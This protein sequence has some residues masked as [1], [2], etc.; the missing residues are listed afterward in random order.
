MFNLSFG[1]DFEKLYET[2]LKIKN[3]KDTSMF[4]FRDLIRDLGIYDDGRLVYFEENKYIN[5]R[6]EI[7]QEPSQFGSLLSFLSNQKINTYCE[8]GPFKYWSFVL[9]CA[10]LSRNTNNI[11]ALGV[12]YMHN[13]CLEITQ[14]LK[15]LNIDHTHYTRDSHYIKDR[16]FDL[17]FID[18]DHSYHGVKTDW[19]NVGQYANICLFHDINDINVKNCERDQ[20]GPRRVFEEL[21]GA[22]ITFTTNNPVMGIGV[23]FP[24]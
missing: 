18:A 3:T 21:E 13:P 15:K 19:I 10:A 6:S 2:A 7:W 9:I 8:I 4:Y 24:K 1:P 23:V 22:K 11:K 20:D 5:P 12:D 14:I 17:V 16:V